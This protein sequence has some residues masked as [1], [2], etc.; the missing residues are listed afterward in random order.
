MAKTTFDSLTPQELS[1]LATIL[2]FAI[3]EGRNAEDLGIISN[4]ISTVG[5]ILGTMA[6]QQSILDEKQDAVKQ[7]DGL[8]QQIADLKKGI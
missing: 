8:K 7:I 1:I 3:A 2:S 6:A 4:F 5:S